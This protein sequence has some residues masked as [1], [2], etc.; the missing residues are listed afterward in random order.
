MKIWEKGGEKDAQKVVVS[1][2]RQKLLIDAK[3]GDLKCLG[4]IR[5]KYIRYKR[6]K[7]TN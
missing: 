3:K 7:W 1:L 6:N 4:L 5:N 2:M